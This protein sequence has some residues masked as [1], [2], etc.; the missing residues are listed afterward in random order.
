MTD[1]TPS[2]DY[3]TRAAVTAWRT[4][5]D[6]CLR[7]DNTRSAEVSLAGSGDYYSVDYWHDSPER[8]AEIV[9]L[10]PVDA[11]DLLLRYRILGLTQTEIAEL[12]SIPQTKVS[13]RIR[14]AEAAFVALLGFGGL[15]PEPVVD[16]ILRPL[17]R[18]YQL[19]RDRSGK[20]VPVRMAAVI[21]EY[22]ET[23]SFVAIASEHRISRVDVRRHLRRLTQQLLGR[24]DL[25]LRPKSNARIVGDRRAP[26]LGAWLAL[27]LARSRAAQPAKNRLTRIN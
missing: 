25:H 7:G 17:G 22:G 4:N 14:V 26:M 5:P 6:A 9:R 16:D 20:K 19:F 15:P 24:R 11:A 21:R 18:E 8:W 2:S 27:L 3:T 13:E 12:L 10:L 1:R 23:H